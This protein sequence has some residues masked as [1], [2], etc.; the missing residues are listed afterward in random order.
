MIRQGRDH[1]R[2]RKLIRPDREIGSCVRLYACRG[3]RPRRRGDEPRRLTRYSA[4]NMLDAA[5]K[6]YARS[7]SGFPGYSMLGMRINDW[8]RPVGAKSISPGRGGPIL[9]LKLLVLIEIDRRFDAA[10]L[11]M[12]HTR[13]PERTW[14]IRAPVLDAW[15]L[16]GPLSWLAN[17]LSR[18]SLSEG[19]PRFLVMVVS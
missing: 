10:V 11:S 13:T 8:E 4:D 1:H 16:R 7:R 3:S 2:G 5:S 17:Q 14:L 18:L 19:A 9:K 6:M 15:A 12:T